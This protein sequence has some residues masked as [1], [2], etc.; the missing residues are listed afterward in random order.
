QAGL[1][2]TGI[3]NAAAAGRIDVLFLVGAD[4]LA[5]Y[6]DRALAS[7]ALH[8][9][10]FVVA[11]DAFATRSVIRAAD[12]VLPAAIYTER[13]GTFTNIE[14][15]I[16]WLGQKVNPPG[17]A[18]PDWVIAAELATRLGIDLGVRSLE[19]L[20]AEV[21]RLSPLHRGVS[22]ALLVSR[23]GRNGVV[24][25]LDLQSTVPESGAVPPPLDPMADPGIASAEERLAPPAPLSVADAGVG[26]TDA[27]GAGAEDLQAHGGAAAGGPGLPGGP[28][29]ADRPA[30]QPAAA[31]SDPWPPML[32]IGPP[33][34]TAEKGPTPPN[35]HALRLVT[36][37]PMWDGGTLVQRSP[38]LAGLHP[39]L[40]LRVNPS[41]LP[42]L[43]LQPGS[44]A[45]ASSGSG[46]LVL[47]VVADIEV[48]P[49]TAMVP[50]NLPEG[51]AGE[52]IGATGALTGISI[53]P[54]GH[55][56]AGQAEDVP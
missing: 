47:P 42:R 12:V 18:W 8:H 33:T 24:V 5:D 40:A 6:P 52:L 11:I 10:R 35:G 36:T 14:G 34:P 30:P 3:L 53:G 43:G 41:D 17:T 56:E 49:G 45:R 7:A 19:D 31:D 44:H 1:D 51:G 28:T 23:Q 32:H 9:A 15:R 46:S 55:V 16:T 27:P 26:R 37:R 4:P 13:R 54:A 20:W 50:F 2:T 39:P 22:R 25:P 38:S 29:P 21:E 48:A